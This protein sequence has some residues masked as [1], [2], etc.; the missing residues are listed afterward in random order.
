MDFEKLELAFKSQ[1]RYFVFQ[2][3][4]TKGTMVTAMEKPITIHDFGGFTQALFD[5]QYPAAGSR[6]GTTKP[7]KWLAELILDWIKNG[8]GPWSLECN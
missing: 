7:K 5:V 8:I 4:E 2:Y 6:I 1:K 3:W